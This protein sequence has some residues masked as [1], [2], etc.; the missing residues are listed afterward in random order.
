MAECSNIEEN[1]Q[2]TSRGHSDCTE[3]RVM[4]PGEEW[5]PSPDCDFGQLPTYDEKLK[6]VNTQLMEKVDALEK[7][8]HKLD[9]ERDA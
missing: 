7:I 3:V 9:R 8:I 2:L 5:Y 4:M 6:L 1:C